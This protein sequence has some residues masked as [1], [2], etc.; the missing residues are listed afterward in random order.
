MD[1]VSG[2]GAVKTMKIEAWQID[3]VQCLS[4]IQNL[5]PTQATLLQGRLNL[6]ATTSLEQFGEPFVAKT[7]DHVEL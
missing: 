4:L 6:A 2:R 7:L 5:Q 3:F 1:T